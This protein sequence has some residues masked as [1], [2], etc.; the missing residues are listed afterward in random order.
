MYFLSNV[1][2]REPRENFYHETY[3]AVAY[4]PISYTYTVRW[5]NFYL[6]KTDQ[7]KK[8]DILS[9]IKKN[10]ESLRIGIKVGQQTRVLYMGSTCPRLNFTN[11]NL[12]TASRV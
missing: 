1:A 12:C 8:Q 5:V 4:L 9:A 2:K 6:T 3:M 10:K 7:W 11:Y